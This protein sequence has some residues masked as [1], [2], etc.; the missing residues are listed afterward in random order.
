MGSNVPDSMNRRDMLK[1]SLMSGGALLLSGGSVH[2]APVQLPTGGF[3]DPPSPSITNPFTEELHRMPIKAALPGGASDLSLADNGGVAPNGTVYPQVPGNDALVTTYSN[4]L[5]RIVALQQ[6]NS[7]NNVQFPPKRFYVLNV[8]Q[9]RHIFHPDPPYSTDGGSTIW[10]Y[11][12]IYPGPTFISRH[13]VPI[14]VRIINGLYFDNEAHPRPPGRIAGGFGNPRISTHLHNGHTGSESDGNPVDVYPPAS[15]LPHLPQYPASIQ[16]LKFRDH[17]YALFR[18][19]LD[20]TVPADK[21]APNKND[22]DIAESVS[23]LWYHDHAMDFTSQNTYKGLVGYHLVFDEIDSGNEND[24]APGALRLPSGE[25]DIPLL[26]QDKRFVLDEKGQAQ[27]F[28]PAD[29]FG[30]LGDVFT[31]NG[32]IQPKLKVLR[33]KYRF[34]LLNAGPSRFYQFYLTK[35]LEDQAVI[36]IGNDESLLEEPYHVPP[37]EGI[38]LAVA[39][40]M[41]VVIDFSPYKKGDKL[42][43]VNRLVMEDS[44]F[45]PVANIDTSVDP[46]RFLNF[47]TLPADESEGKGDY[48]LCFEV[49]DGVPD[50]PSRVPV[51][52]RKNPVIPAYTKDPPALLKKRSNHREFVFD[53]TADGWVINGRPFDPSPAGFAQLRVGSLDTP[54]SV[55]P[56]ESPDGEVWTIRNSQ[57]SGWAHPVHIHLEEFRILWRNEVA[58]PAYEL[59]KKD[60]LRLDP[61]EEVQIFLRFRDFLGKYPIHCHNVVHEDHEMMLRFD[62]VG[63]K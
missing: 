10:G 7:G 25:F 9:A 12:G 58:P 49:G 18:A 42:F 47:K 56:G 52:L 62:V 17:H 43:L 31:V 63:D 55:S 51:N 57:F 3:F 19:G 39:E 6:R 4:S 41:D 20:P 5:E 59:C 11:D 2:A 23:T 44:G 14:L 50:D 27:L 26:F 36:R 33:R 29:T 60:V 45:G 37:Q 38:L 24:L 8:R 35:E 32:Q 46:P 1:L 53:L 15:A 61:L 34:R 30:V 22:G 16:N 13:G 21:P 40:R 54:R 48:I 28:L